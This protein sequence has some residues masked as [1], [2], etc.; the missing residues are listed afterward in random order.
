MQ[1]NT[2]IKQGLRLTEESAMR[3]LTALE[4]MAIRLA[5]RVELE[6]LGAVVEGSHAA[7]TKVSYQIRRDR[8][9]ELLGLFAVGNTIPIGT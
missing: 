6:W 2:S 3:K 4:M 1:E 7:E 9:E 5:L 8:V